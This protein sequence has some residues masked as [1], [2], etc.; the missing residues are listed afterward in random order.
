MRA[1]HRSDA[2]PQ[3][4][5]LI[6]VLSLI[7]TT[8]GCSG[9]HTQSGGV[10]SGNSLSVTS[11]NPT[12]GPVGTSV[13]IT[14]TNFGS[15]QGTSTV[16]FNGTL[17]TPTNWSA[18][19]ITAPVPAGATSG[20]VVV[21]VAGAA[22]NGVFFTVT[23]A[24]GPT[25]TSLNPASGPVATSVTIN[26][27][28]FGSSQGTSTVRFN[29]TLATPTSWSAT[30][31]MAPVPAGATSGNVVVTVNGVA[32]N[33]V[34]FTVTSASGPTI[35][36]LNP[37]SG[38]VGTSVTITGTN[39]GSSQGTSTVT[40]NGTLATPTSWSATSI[41]TPVPAG[42][43]PGNVVVTVAGA[44]SNGVFFTVT[45]ASGPN[46][47]NLNPTSGPV[48]TPVTIT[49]TN[50]GSSQGT[51]TVT[52]NGSLATPTSWSATSIV[53][54]VPTG[55]TSGN[56]LVIVGGFGSNLV[57]FTV[58]GASVS[59]PI[60][61][62][63]NKRYFVGQ[64][65]TPWLMV[66]DAAHH[67]MPVIGSTPSSITTY[68]NSRVAQGFTA[69]NIYG[70]CG[71]SGTCPTTA[72][73]QNGQLPFM[74]GNS[75]ATYD[76]ST[77]NPNYWSQVDALITAADNAG[78]VVLFD[79]LPWGVYFGTTMENV[80]GPINYPTNDFNFGVYLGNR[81]KNFP[82]IIWQFGQDFRHGGGL[83]G[84]QWLPADQNFMDYM[85][86][87]I[88]GVASVD[89]NHL[90]TSQMN[91]Y[92]S[93]TQQGYQVPCNANCTSA[94]WN[95]RF[96]NANNV[97]FVYSYYETYDEMLQAYNCGPSGP[98]TRQANNGTQS[99]GGNAGNAPST[100]FPPSVMPTF[101]G[102]ANYEGANNTGFL[103]SPANAFVMRQQMWYSMTSGAAGFEFG[104]VNVN[105][106][107]SSPLWSNQLN[108]T[109]TQQ[110]KYVN[111]FLKNYNW[112]TFV[113]ETTHQLVTAGYGT[114]NASN[115]NLYKATYATT[116]WDGSSTAIVY[117]PVSTT[118]TVNMAKFSKLVIA[119]WYDPTTGNSTAING[120]LPLPNSGFQTFTTP[121][122]AHTDGS[123]DWVLVLQ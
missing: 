55:A 43:T 8:A 22:S 91:N 87:V 23:S 109:A 33:A 56:V 38:P 95:P 106:F 69:I 88:A 83:V 54:P 52:F 49:G 96:G 100:Q 9:G 103:S 114:Y 26:G 92:V 82:N 93:Y 98:C 58:P 59:F 10:P 16:T 13:T 101:L 57:P 25:I 21:T 123:S 7:L 122:T 76:I 11:L 24:S 36:S 72:S 18:A 2:V 107:D 45:S 35:T 99:I 12:S 42:A 77:P 4:R 111:S 66:M 28:N 3:V 61:L 51:S 85:A 63:A 50:F 31:I 90:I 39:F 94:Y 19:S 34:F 118:L 75:S 64:N 60:K 30:S 117:T 112:W 89:T 119:S 53:V 116:T 6:L 40:F 62:S 29:G 120:G 86:Q 97:S 78:L 37:A 67:I 20:N 27:T 110:V 71:G 44:V 14:G 46:I 115:G 79:P 47:T 80:V 17:S 1:R 70:A 74:V 5:L 102:E 108:T 113:P 84:G 81:Y 73:A 121:P 32:S 65:G 48:G 41:M 68:I 105:H 15:S 104:M